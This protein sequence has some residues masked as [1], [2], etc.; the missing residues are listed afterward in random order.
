M[1]M[2][3]VD[4]GI[5]PIIGYCFRSNGVIYALYYI[6]IVMMTF[7][8]YWQA[9]TLSTILKYAF[10]SR[11][12]ALPQR[13]LRL[14]IVISALRRTSSPRVIDAQAKCCKMERRAS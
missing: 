11:T 7:N 13:T 9:H 3:M 10:H 5:I 8:Y 14:T 6:L 1:A 12:G 2:K 4:D